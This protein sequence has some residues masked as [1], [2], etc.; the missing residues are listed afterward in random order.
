MDTYLFS[1]KDEYTS[2]LVI[3][4]IDGIYQIIGIYT[5][6]TVAVS[7]NSFYFF[8]STHMD[9]FNAAIAKHDFSS[10]SRNLMET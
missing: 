3:P 4:Q 1:V 7:D 6:I 9:L 8:S 5:E 10:I 2:G